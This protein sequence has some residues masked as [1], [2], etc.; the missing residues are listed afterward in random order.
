V[1][2]P[3]GALVAIDLEDGRIV[4]KSPVGKVDRLQAAGVPATGL[5]SLGGAIATA[6]GLLFIAGTTD[7]RI[8]AFDARTG[9]EL[10]EAELEASGHATPATYFSERSGR[11]FL[12]IAAGGGGYL[13]PGHV[14]DALVAFALPKRP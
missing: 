4:W 5:P 11:Q 13:S 7:R 3:W 10:W 14:S 8:R 9:K 1:K 2:P 6:G 12:V